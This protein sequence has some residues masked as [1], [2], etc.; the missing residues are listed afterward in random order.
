MVR[1]KIKQPPGTIFQTKNSGP[2]TLLYHIKGRDCVVEFPSGFTR[3][4]EYRNLEKGAVKDPFYPTVHGK[5]Y[6]GIGPYRI[7]KG[8]VVERAYIKWANILS[9]CYIRRPITAPWEDVEVC[10]EWLNYQNFARWYE[11][12]FKYYMDGW[13]IDKDLIDKN[14]KIYS[15]DTCVFL[16]KE[17][18]GALIS[19][20][21]GST[22]TGAT[23]R[24]L[25]N[26]WVAAVWHEDGFK[27]SNVFNTEQEALDFQ[28]SSKEFKVRKLADKWK[29][30]LSDK[31]Y[32]ALQSW[33]YIRLNGEV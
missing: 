2:C 20:V 8:K 10:D 9:R 24:P 13:E 32:Q 17:I 31:A 25:T 33:E 27:T 26:N 15:P 23:F 4:V 18:N 16:P 1:V 29:D 21:R 12:N 30:L 11:G 5:G 14:S 19:N 6:T 28:K 22:Y 7:S 3:Q